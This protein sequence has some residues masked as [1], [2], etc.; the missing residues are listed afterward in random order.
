MMTINRTDQSLIGEWWWT[1]DR[2]ALAAVLALISIGAVL[3]LAASPGVAVR[4]RLDPFHFIY[5]Q[6]VFLVPALVVLIGSSLL[7]PR[8]VFRVSAILFVVSYVLMVMTLIIGPDVNGSTRWLSLGGLSIQPS[9]FMK[10]SLT[11]LIAWLLTEGSSD[12]GGSRNSAPTLYSK[13][14]STALVG[15]VVIVLALQPD[16]GQAVL[17]L[18]L[19]GGL[20]FVAGL[21]MIWVGGLGLGAM[22][23]AGGAYLWMPH[24]TSRIDLFLYPEQ[25]DNYQIDQA[26]EAFRAGGF[27]GRGPGEGQVKAILPDAHTD[28]IF[29]VAVEEYGFIAGALI[30]VL[31][32]FI[33]L[34]SLLRSMKESDR[35]AQ[36]S[37]SAL[38]GLFGA[39]ALF[40][41]G[42]NLN[43]LPSKGMTLPFIS[44]GGSSLLALSLT[45]GMALALTRRRPGCAYAIVLSC[46][47]RES[48]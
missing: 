18:A 33:V 42:V 5:R 29:A 14:I 35:F 10:P 24:V 9:E 17:L 27:T 45:M 23:F 28:Y 46:P 12:Y 1:I 30:I 37:G 20:L 44:Y 2:W 13:S 8:Q 11:V 4:L 36:F 22:A 31:F 26:L 25:R 38:V 47:L 16:F 3:I 41:L 21:P 32:A 19:W 34:R 40:N 6:F 7:T 39:Q 48:S 43:V 15:V